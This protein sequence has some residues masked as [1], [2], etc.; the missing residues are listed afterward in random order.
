M[1]FPQ[2]AGALKD[3]L[4]DVLGKNDDITFFEYSKKSSKENALTV[5]GIELVKKEDL[6]PLIARM[7]ALNFYGEYLNDKPNLFEFLV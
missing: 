6:A 1:R 7:K 3:F 5:V 4:M 2:R